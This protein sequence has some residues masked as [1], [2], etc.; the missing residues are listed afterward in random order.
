M[1]N[2]KNRVHKALRWSEK[3]TKTDM[4]YVAKGG[5]WLIFGYGFQLILG[6]VLATSFANLLSKEAYGTYQFVISMASIVGVFTLSGMGTAVSRAVA[7]GREGVLRYGTKI[8]A[9]WSLGIVIASV[10]LAIYYFTKDNLV[11]ATSFA[12]VTLTQPI[13]TTFNLYKPYLQGK[14][15][16]KESVVLENIQRLVPFALL[17]VTF[18]FSRNPVVLIAVYFFSQ[19]LTYIVAYTVTVRRHKLSLIPDKETIGYGKHLSVMNSFVELSGSVDKSSIWIFLGAAP[20]AAYGLAI[21]PIIH[22][23]SIFGFIHQLAFPKMA[24]KKLSELQEVIPQKIRTYWFVILLVVIIYIILAPF[25]FHTLFPKYPE[26]VLYSQVLALSLLAIP[27]A[28]VDQTFIAHK[29]TKELYWVNITKPLARILLLIVGIPLFGIWGAIGAILLS[30]WYAAI[31]Q[32]FLF[33]RIDNY[34]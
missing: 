9:K 26:A 30:E 12:V 10:A 31:L 32:W 25:L 20:T 18:V 34:I 29:M 28:F 23:Q 27:R 19:A 24:R 14:Q 22:M 5:S 33:K 13:I 15:L 21:L 2:L 7:Q 11:L 16:F 1:K 8:M 4:L 17:M 3:Y 6:I